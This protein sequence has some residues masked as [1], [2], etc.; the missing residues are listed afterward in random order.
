[1]MRAYLSDWLAS[2][3]VM[4]GAVAASLVVHGLLLAIHFVAPQWLQVKAQDPGLEI[5]LVNAKTLRAPTRA[6]VLAQANFEGGGDKDQG[7]ATSPLP[8]SGQTVDGDALAEMKRKTEA[9]EAQQREML[10]QMQSNRLRLEQQARWLENNPVTG[11]D[12]NETLR[13]I[14]RQ[15]A[16]IETRIQE[17]NQRPKKH[18]YGASALDSVAALYVENFRQRVERWGTQHYPDAAR[19]RVYGSVQI[20]VTIDRFGQI[21]SLEL[22]KSSGHKVLDDAALNIVRR[23]AP[24]GRFGAD[25]EKQMG[26]LA[27]TRT[28]MF[29]NNILEVHASR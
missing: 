4:A 25:M 14:K 15:T 10:S 27:I 3:V 23:A 22:N 20:T 26:L 16:I 8:N 11:A 5:V 1:M 29:T 13:Q 2:N 28:V 7:R 21:Y 17:E 24:Y 19:G 6:E 18:H 9:L 12:L